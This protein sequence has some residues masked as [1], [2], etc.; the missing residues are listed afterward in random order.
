MLRRFFACLVFLF[1]VATTLS[2]IAA[3]PSPLRPASRITAP[4]DDNVRVVLTAASI[5]WLGRKTTGEPC[6]RARR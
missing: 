5:L 2:A 4:V 6:H 1:F 3:N